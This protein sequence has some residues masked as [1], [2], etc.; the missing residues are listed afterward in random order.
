MSIHYNELLTH[1]MLKSIREKGYY[2]STE[3][4][5]SVAEDNRKVAD[6]LEACEAS[7]VQWRDEA[8]L[9]R[10]RTSLLENTLSD[11][12]L[13]SKSCAAS[14]PILLEIADKSNELIKKRK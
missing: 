1:Q 10:G 12:R 8:C 2:K 4:W 3:D 5:S 13:L 7:R 6:Q 9:L 14:L 11:I